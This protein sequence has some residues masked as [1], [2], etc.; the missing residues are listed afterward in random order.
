MVCDECGCSLE[1]HPESK[2]LC[3]A[4]EQA[5]IDEMLAKFKSASRADKLRFKDKIAAELLARGRAVDL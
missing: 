4:C 3:R 1:N 2:G 5:F